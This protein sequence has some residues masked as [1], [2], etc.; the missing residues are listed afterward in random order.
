MQSVLAGQFCYFIMG[1]GRDCVVCIV[2]S[3]VDLAVGAAEGA[4]VVDEFEAHVLY[5]VEIIVSASPGDYDGLGACI[6]PYESLDLRGCILD[7]RNLREVW[8]GFA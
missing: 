1:L 4:L 7:H 6:V 5:P 3:C 2:E 8:V